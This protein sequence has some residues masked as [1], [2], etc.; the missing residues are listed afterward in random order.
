[1]NTLLLIAKGFIIYPVIV[2]VM[3]GMGLLLFGWP[4]KE[5]AT[6]PVVA[7]VAGGAIWVLILVVGFAIFL[8]IDGRA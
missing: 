8:P 6:D 2:G 4:S 1:M 7:M 5:T 3:A